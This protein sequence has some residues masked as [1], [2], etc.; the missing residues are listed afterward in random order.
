MQYLALKADKRF[1]KVNHERSFMENERIVFNAEV[2]NDA[3]EAV[4]DPEVSIVF[5][6]EDGK[7]YPFTFSRSA[8]AYRLDAGSLPTGTY[9]YL[10]STSRG[11]EKLEERGSITVKPFDLEGANLTA[12]HGLLQAM[13]DATGGRVFY[14][15]NA[16]E[17]NGYL[18]ETA[19][20]S[21]VS[22]TTEVFDT[23]LNL[24]WIFFVILLLLSAE[25]F[26][27]KRSGNY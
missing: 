5:K 26:L 21:P 20:L 8:S 13:A 10:A 18:D 12:D 15:E 23:V 17:I 24:K 19:S 7:D 27:R 9:S 25:W 11:G 4:N 2:Y 14:P 1:F 22:Y 3:Y 16:G 6:D